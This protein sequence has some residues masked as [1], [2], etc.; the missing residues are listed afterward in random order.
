MPGRLTGCIVDH[1]TAAFD[2]QCTIVPDGPCNIVAAFTFC[3]NFRRQFTDCALNAILLRIL[4]CCAVLCNIQ[5]NIVC[6]VEDSCA[7]ALN[8]IR[9]IQ[10]FQSIH[11]TECVCTDGGQC[12]ILRNDDIC[13]R[14]AEVEGAHCDLFNTVGDLDLCQ[15]GIAECTNTDAL[16]HAAVLKDDL[17]QILQFEE[18]VVT[19]RGDLCTNFNLCNIVS[20]LIIMPG[21]LSCC[22]VNH[23][24]AAFNLQCT[25]VP[26]SPCGVIAAFACCQR[27]GRQ[28]TDCAL[29]A[30]LLRIL[31]SCA[32]LCN[33]QNNIVC[34]VECCCTNGFNAIGQVE[35]FQC[36]HIT[37]CVCTD[38]SQYGILR[39]GDVC[40]G[41]A[42]VE[43]AHGDLFDAVGDLDLCQAGVTKGTNTD[44]LQIAVAFKCDLN[45]VFQFKEAVITD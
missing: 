41:L 15:A 11:I 37:E 3:N 38:S 2:L 26:D 25:I 19:D 28:F 43:G 4:M 39:N 40:Q 6:V 20:V 23:S 29:N 31:M 33:I 32:V 13:Q 44:A 30:V 9:Q 42:E 16:Q 12:G 22:I 1:C 14:L 45:H 10:I 18:A 36:I 8:A 7:Q 24:T 17:G 5:N 21:R 35:G 34:V 27:C